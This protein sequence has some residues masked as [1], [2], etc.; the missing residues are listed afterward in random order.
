[1]SAGDTSKLS[2]ATPVLVS[3]QG[4]SQ[5]DTALQNSS[6]SVGRWIGQVQSQAQSRVSSAIRSIRGGVR[7]A[8]SRLRSERRL[9]RENHPLTA[10]AIIA[11]SAFVLGITLGILKS[12]RS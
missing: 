4:T 10:L 1:M 11:G 9:L 8:A 7:D 5:L 3:S 12:R 2:S 6:A